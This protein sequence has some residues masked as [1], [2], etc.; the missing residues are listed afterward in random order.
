M[1]MDAPSLTQT[2]AGPHDAGDA[3][4]AAGPPPARGG[5]CH[6]QSAVPRGHLPA[7]APVLGA[8][9]CNVFQNLTGAGPEAGHGV[10]SWGMAL[11]HGASLLSGVPAV[12]ARRAR[13]TSHF[14]PAPPRCPA[15]SRASSLLGSQWQQCLHGWLTVCQIRCTHT[16]SCCP[17]AS[18]WSRGR[19]RVGAQGRRCGMHLPAAGPVA[20]RSSVV[21]CPCMLAVQPS[22]TGMR[23]EQCLCF[24]SSLPNTECSAGGGPAP[25]G[26]PAVPLDGAERGGHGARAGT[27][28]GTAASGPPRRAQLLRRRRRPAKSC[29][30]ALHCPTVA[31]PCN[32]REKREGSLWPT[33]VPPCMLVLSHQPGLVAHSPDSS[34]LGGHLSLSEQRLRPSQPAPQPWTSPRPTANPSGRA[35]AKAPVAQPRPAVQE[36]PLPPEIQAPRRPPPPRIMPRQLWQWPA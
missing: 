11:L 10:A 36:R 14:S 16:S 32:A 25:L 15:P 8:L 18:R 23:T 22:G 35:P 34:Q 2:P 19:S 17:R 24:T 28:G 9:F 31:V 29:T 7:G 30:A 12:P 27:E 33:R 21:P 26:G 5:L 4:A 6:R 20:A 3:R 1:S 13:P